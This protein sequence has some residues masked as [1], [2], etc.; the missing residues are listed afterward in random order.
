MSHA[1]DRCPSCGLPYDR[2]RTGL[3]FGTVRSM[4]FTSSDEPSLWRQKH[5]RAVLGFWHELKQHYWR[6]H[7]ALCAPA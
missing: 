7:L 5:R 6:E 2:L 4:M 3:S 1:V